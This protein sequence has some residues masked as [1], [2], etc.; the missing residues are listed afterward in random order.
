MTYLSVET[1]NVVTIFYD[2]LFVFMSFLSHLRVAGFKIYV[3]AF[4]AT[5][6]FIKQ[7]TCTC[8]R[9]THLQVKQQSKQVQYYKVDPPEHVYVFRF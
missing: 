5:L 2:L 4:A 3:F 8:V 6:S 9:I 7:S 1:L